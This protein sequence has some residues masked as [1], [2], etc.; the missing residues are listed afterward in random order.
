MNPAVN[1]VM[2]QLAIVVN[3]GDRCV[4]IGKPGNGLGA[5]IERLALK[6]SPFRLSP[7]PFRPPIT[8]QLVL[9]N[10][11]KSLQ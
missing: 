2:V 11:R 9:N 10:S 3:C 8:I 4:L 1:N 6:S 5:S 7:F